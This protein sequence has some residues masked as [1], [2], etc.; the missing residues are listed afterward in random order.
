[1]RNSTGTP[2]FRSARALVP[3]DG[4]RWQARFASSHLPRSVRRAEE[5][6]ASQLGSRLDSCGRAWFS[7]LARRTSYWGGT[8]RDDRG[9]RGFRHPHSGRNGPCRGRP[10]TANGILK[11]ARFSDVK[12]AR[13]DLNRRPPGYQP[14]R[15][16]ICR[17]EGLYPIWDPDDPPL[18]ALERSFAWLAE[19][20]YS[21]VARSS[22]END[23][24]QLD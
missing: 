21:E 19:F 16:G 2:R 18:D 20:A 4:P 7:E 15:Q 5:R 3:S 6:L 9:I 1:R 23:L 8:G 24:D 11:T 13:S 10:P 12:W 22:T 14:A 17:S